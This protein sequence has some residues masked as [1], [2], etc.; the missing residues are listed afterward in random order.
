MKK[1]KM[2]TPQEA[3]KYCDLCPQCIREMMK[4]KA[5]DFGS[6][7]NVTGRRWRFVI[8]PAKFFGWLGQSIPTEW[9]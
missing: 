2:M 3:S 7:V 9:R 5:V 8:V 1:V 4:A 6:A